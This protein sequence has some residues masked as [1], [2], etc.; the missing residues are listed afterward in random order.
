MPAVEVPDRATQSV[1]SPAPTPG[2]PKTTFIQN[3]G[4]MSVDRLGVTPV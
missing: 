3:V 4:S 1:A 2:T